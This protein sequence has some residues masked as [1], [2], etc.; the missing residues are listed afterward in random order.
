MAQN[1]ISVG[2]EHGQK[3]WLSTST[4]ASLRGK[5]SD[6]LRI[7]DAGSNFI[8][9]AWPC[10][11]T[12]CDSILYSCCVCKKLQDSANLVQGIKLL[13]S[14]V[15]KE[16]DIALVICSYK[17]VKQVKLDLELHPGKVEKFCRNLLYKVCADTNFSIDVTNSPLG[18]IFGISS[19]IVDNIKDVHLDK[20]GTPFEETGPKGYVIDKESVVNIKSIVS[21]ERTRCNQK[22]VNIGGFDR[23]TKELCDLFEMCLHCNPMVKK[24]LRKLVPKGI[25]L[26]G[27]SGTG[28]TSLVKHVAYLCNACVITVNGPEVYGA[29]PGETEENLSRILDKALIMSEEGPTILFLD[30][31]DTLCQNQLA[32]DGGKEVNCSLH[33]ASF[34]DKIVN[35]VNLIVMGATN[36]LTSVDRALRRPGR[37]DKEVI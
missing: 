14:K 3:C 15:C 12:E 25:L 37:F 32:S 6:Y 13:E 29:R 22:P 17:R 8:C 11:E 27:P 4:L 21:R 18:E 1:F 34:F 2:I 35:N 10:D 31:V 30:E 19:I 9:Q 23:E 26:H 20:H 33:I 28:K 24:D 7:S 36:R 5:F 16:V